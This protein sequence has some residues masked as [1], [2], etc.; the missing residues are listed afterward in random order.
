[1]VSVPEAINLKRYAIIRILYKLFCLA[2]ISHA[3][4][5]ANSYCR[6]TVQGVL[7]PVPP[8]DRDLVGR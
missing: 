3:C 4:Y 5:I 8:G 1:M 6:D 2:P 7:G